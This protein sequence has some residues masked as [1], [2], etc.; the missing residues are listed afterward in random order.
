[1]APGHSHLS[2]GIPDTNKVAN[3]CDMSFKGIVVIISSSIKVEN[4]SQPDNA[5]YE[6]HIRKINDRFQE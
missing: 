5:Q 6:D 2:C 3:N 1:M 4:V